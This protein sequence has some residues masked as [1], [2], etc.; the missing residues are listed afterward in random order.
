MIQTPVP[1]AADGILDGHRRLL[2]TLREF[3][4]VIEPGKPPDCDTLR[5]IVAFLRQE[6][7]SFS[8][9]E[10]SALAVGTER[11]TA[12]FEH[13]FL[14]AEIDAFAHAVDGLHER[15]LGPDDPGRRKAADAVLRH[16]HRI[17][18]VLELHVLKFEDDSLAPEGTAGLRRAMRTGIPW[19]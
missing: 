6:V 4:P 13:A 1:M 15:L 14:A 10:E 19:S 8:R 17:E 3:R 5:G 12:A 11:E 2:E 18:A 7:P 9:R 16:A